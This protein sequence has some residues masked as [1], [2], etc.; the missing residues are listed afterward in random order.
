VRGQ[1]RQWKEKLAQQYRQFDRAYCDHRTRSFAEDFVNRSS[2]QGRRR[3][4]GKLKRAFGPGVTLEGLRLDGNYPMAV[5]SL[6]SS[7][8]SV[9]A[10][11]PMESGLAQDCVTVNCV[12]AGRLPSPTE[13]GLAEGLWSL[14][15]PD[16]ALGRRSSAAAACRTRSSPRRITTCCVCARVNWSNLS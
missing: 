7:R 16:H 14:E 13:A 12:L 3:A 5:W 11:A 4:L 8:E 6:L 15:I 10:G 2:R 9:T 1:L